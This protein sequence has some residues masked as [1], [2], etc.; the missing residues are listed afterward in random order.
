MDLLLRG[1]DQALRRARL[2]WFSRWRFGLHYLPA[3]A[4]TL[5]ISLWYGLLPA[6]VETGCGMMRGLLFGGEPLL[7]SARMRREEDQCRAL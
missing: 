4:R 7:R 5:H 6:S 1:M 3:T 2:M